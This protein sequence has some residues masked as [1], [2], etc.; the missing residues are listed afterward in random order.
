M[1][2]QPRDC[3]RYL[4]FVRSN[5]FSANC[6]RVEPDMKFL[7]PIFGL[8]ALL[9]AMPPALATDNALKQIAV[10]T[11]LHLIQTLTLSD[12]QFLMGDSAGEPVTIS[13]QFRIAQGS[14]RLPVVILQHASSGYDARIDVWSR[15]L[16]ELGISTFALDGFTVRGLTDINNSQ[17][18]LGRLNLILDIYRALDVLAKHPR[19]DATR[20]ALMGFSRGGQATL[21]ASLGR[22]H[23][24]WNKSGAEFAAYVP[25]YPDCMTTFLS[26][27]EVVNRPIRIFGGTLDDYNPI[28][29]CKAYAERLRAASRDVEVTEYPNASH[30][31]D[32]PLGAQPAKIQ[33]S[34][35]SVRNC[36]IREEA[37]GLLINADT[38]Q[39]FTYEDACVV[40]GPHT[41]Y[42]P[43]ATEAA[44]AT[45]KA[46]FKSVFK[47]N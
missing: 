7:P 12:Q 19:V 13:G 41:G 23:K 47:L 42:D 4:I 8:V 39:S 43:V 10:R 27:T 29:A 24:L 30:S 46:F 33:P 38:K 34:F 22:F 6:L 35:E 14:G 44:R 3:Y 31:F 25:F 11:E 15:E 16:N 36:K 26:D 1:D 32:N 28:S 45:V 21:Y 37:N 2:E 9:V 40:H 5:S 18:S 17:A 20:I